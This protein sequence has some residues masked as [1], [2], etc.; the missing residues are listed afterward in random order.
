MSEYSG[1]CI[2][3]RADNLLNTH[4]RKMPCTDERGLLRIYW[5]VAALN[6]ATSSAGTRPRSFTST[7]WALAHSRT[8]V[9]FSSLAGPR[10]PP[11]VDP[12]QER[13]QFPVLGKRGDHG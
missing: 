11:R 7:R 2:D 3:M 12:I 13:R 1:M 10:R 4:V 5:L 9:V 8:C 6:L